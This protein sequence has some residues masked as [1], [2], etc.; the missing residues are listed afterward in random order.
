MSKLSDIADSLR[1]KNLAPNTDKTTNEYNSSSPEVIADANG[2]PI[3]IAT[4]G[5]DLATNTFSP[6]KE[7]N[8]GNSG[9]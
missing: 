7:Y 6:V 3:D 4:R 9:L 2:T 8:S 1:G 5:K